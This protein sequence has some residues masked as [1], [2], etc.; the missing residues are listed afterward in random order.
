[1]RTTALLFLL[2]LASPA[3]G[4][5]LT[6]YIVKNAGISR[7]EET[8]ITASSRLSLTPNN[9]D[10]AIIVLDEKRPPPRSLGDISKMEIL[11]RYEFF[12]A[13]GFK[14]V[15]FLENNLE[16]FN[17]TKKWSDVDRSSSSIRGV[18]R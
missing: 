9:T 18:Q 4:E 11:L 5:F 14:R 17:L 8:E 13:D 6:Y 16:K 10:Y 12:E 2:F 1:M 15:R 7:A 3:R